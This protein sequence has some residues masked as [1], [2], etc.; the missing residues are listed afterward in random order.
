MMSDRRASVTISTS[1]S[2]HRT[3]SRKSAHYSANYPSADLPIAPTRMQNDQTAWV[4]RFGLVVPKG[5]V[6]HRGRLPITR[7]DVQSEVCTAT[8]ESG[9]GLSLPDMQLMLDTSGSC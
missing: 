6:G 7:S 1:G 3:K 8:G 2:R 4:D 5:A 9:R